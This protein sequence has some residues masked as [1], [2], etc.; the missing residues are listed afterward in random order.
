METSSNQ[1][2]KNSWKIAIEND[3]QSLH[4]KFVILKIRVKHQIWVMHLNT[5]I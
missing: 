3:N 5:L 4:I 2:W 1:K